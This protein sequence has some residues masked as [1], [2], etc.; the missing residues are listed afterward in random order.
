ML[1]FLNFLFIKK[2][3]RIIFKNKNVDH[4]HMCNLKYNV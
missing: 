4:Q 3:L 2:I 1:L